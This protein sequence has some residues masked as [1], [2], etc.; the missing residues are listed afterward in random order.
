MAYPGDFVA[1]NRAARTDAQRSAVYLTSVE[2]VSGSGNGWP[3]AFPWAFTHA[4]RTGFTRDSER[5]S[6]SI[7]LKEQPAALCQILSMFLT[8]NVR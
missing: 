2:P 4:A 6:T 8:F 5:G 1:A 7:T 3:S